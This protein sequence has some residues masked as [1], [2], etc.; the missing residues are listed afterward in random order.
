MEIILSDTKPAPPAADFAFEIDFKKGEGSASRVF[1]ATH[2]FIKACE[3]LDAELVQSIDASIETVMMLEDI[4]IGSIKTWLRTALL[5]VNDDALK[6]MDWKKQV[7][8]YL[9]KAKYAVIKWTE[10]E[11]AP[12]RL[13]D[14]RRE[15]QRIAAETDVRHLPD[16]SP[17]SPNALVN[18]MRD[19]QR[20]K[21]HLIEGD[22]ATMITPNGEV[23]MRLSL[24][25]PLEDIEAL[26]VARTLSQP[27]SPMILA[28]KKPDYLGTSRWDLRHGKRTIQAK[29]EDEP[30]LRRFQQRAVDV[31]P[32]DA[33][34]CTVRIELLYGHDNELLQERYTILSVEEVLVNRFV[35]DELPFDEPD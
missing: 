29:I 7:G 18:A 21:A 3:A 34:Q 30:W 2:D 32:G 11:D 9:V 1:A 31:R 15:I 12:Q 35:I 17:P 25:W 28:V 8:S 10:T 16:Y 23:E 27:A 22:R 26:A 4:E 19:I 6:D 13:P 14:L 5:S 24:R 33:L 20:T